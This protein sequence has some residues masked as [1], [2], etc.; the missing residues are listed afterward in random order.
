MNVCVYFTLDHSL[1]SLLL[2]HLVYSV[3]HYTVSQSVRQSDVR[4]VGLLGACS[5][6]V[7]I[8]WHAT[9]RYALF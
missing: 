4:S 5:D 2:E 9:L 6:R 1:C 8:E 3:F 7:N